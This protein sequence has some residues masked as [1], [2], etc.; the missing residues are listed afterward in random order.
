MISL[1]ALIIGTALMFGTG[2]IVSHAQ[3]PQSST[4]N[5][6]KNTSTT[7]ITV[8]HEM[9]TVDSI[10]NSE[11]VLTHEYKGKTEN[12]KFMMDANTKKDGTINKG[13][14]VEVFYHA[15]NKQRILSEVK[16]ESKHS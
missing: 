13:D 16:P 6:T 2:G 9:G 5:T 3:T 14:R 15:Q 4:T 7:T 11:L 8:H 10:T 1:K 12:T